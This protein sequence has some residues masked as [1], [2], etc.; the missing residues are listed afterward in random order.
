MNRRGRNQYIFATDLN[1]RRSG[2]FFRAFLVILIVLILFVAATNFIS[3]HRLRYIREPVTIA[4]LPE[5]L[6]G[7]AILQFSDLQGREGLTDMI[8]QAI[9]N[10]V[11]SCIVFTGDMVGKSGNV[12]PLLEIAGLF[13]DTPKYL[14]QGDEDPDYLDTYAHGNL[15]AYADWAYAAVESGIEILDEPVLFTQ[16]RNGRARLWLV[17]EMLY[18]LDLDMMETQYRNTLSRFSGS[19]LQEDQAAYR[20]V[21]EYQLNRIASIREKIRSMEKSDIQIA[22]THVPLTEDYVKTMLSWSDKNSVFSLRSSALVLAGHYAGGQ[23]RI[24]GVGA[25]Y[26]PDL[27][28]FPDDSLV[29]GMGYPGGIAQYISP[30]LSASGIYGLEKGRLYVSPCITSLELTS[31]IAR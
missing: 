23:W 25:L 22:V 4:N 6:E 11:W 20:R 3:S 12:K 29:Q 30:G 13:P 31:N 16:G 5:D 21:A 27:G 1:K 26:V 10:R 7:F 9:G 17:P 8:R 28:F 24:P 19:Q 2:P 15:T 18:S 14:I